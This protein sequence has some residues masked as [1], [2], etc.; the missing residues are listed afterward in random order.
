MNTT[1]VQ[2]KRGVDYLMIA[3]FLAVGIAI[4]RAIFFTPPDANQ[5]VAQK[6]LY[7]HAPAAWASELAFILVGITGLLYLFLKDDRLDRFAASSVEVGLVF[8]VVTI[9]TGPIWAKPIWGGYWNWGDPR[10]TSYTLLALTYLGYMVMRGAVEDPALRARYSAILGIMG[11]LLVPF[12]HVSVLIFNSA[13]PDPILFS[14]N[15]LD[16][17]KRA[18]PDVMLVTLLM[19]LGA[20]TLLYVAFVRSRYRLQLERDLLAAHAEASR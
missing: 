18:L 2:Q 12:V 3:A 8:I 4:V 13:H 19:A 16:P 10:L 6:I 11:A 5:G 17:E 14:P 7:V 20:C 9:T 15:A 1:A